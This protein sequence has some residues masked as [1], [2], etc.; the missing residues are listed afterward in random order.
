MMKIKVLADLF[1]KKMVQTNRQYTNY[2]PVD[3]YV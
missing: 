3:F 1:D 2:S